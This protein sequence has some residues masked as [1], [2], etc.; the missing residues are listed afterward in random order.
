MRLSL[1]ATVIAAAIL[2]GGA[3]LLVGLIHLADPAYGVNFLQMTGSV[4]PWFHSTHGWSVVL[5]RSVE[6]AVDG[7]IAGIIFAALY[8]LVA[9]HTKL[10]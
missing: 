3:I 5:G 4:Y 2:W 9:S 6:A 1:R 8:N 7:A 10:Q